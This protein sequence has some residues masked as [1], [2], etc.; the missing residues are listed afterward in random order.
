M[1]TD[2]GIAEEASGMVRAS[3]GARHIYLTCRWYRGD[4]RTLEIIYDGRVIVD[5]RETTDAATVG[6]AWLDFV[7]YMKES[8]SFDRHR[9]ATLASPAMTA[10]KRNDT[11]ELSNA[12]R[13]VVPARRSL[14]EPQPPTPPC[15]RRCWRRRR[16]GATARPAS[17]STTRP[18]ASRSGGGGAP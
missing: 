15:A 11:D 2:V 9:T 10:S 13:R 17:A 6:A 4:A 8:G 7:A 16:P 1:A 18:N 14:L 3:E 5:G 12:R